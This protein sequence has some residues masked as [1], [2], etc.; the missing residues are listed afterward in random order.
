M[1][2]GSQRTHLRGLAH[3]LRPLVQIGKDGVTQTVVTAVDAVLDAHEL[4][5]VQI[6][7]ER[8]ERKAAA[9]ELEARLGCECAGLIG[10]MAILFRRHR[11]PERQKVVLP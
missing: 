1:L 3:G 2:T 5:K 10:R 8:A 11:D 7:A 9:D 6:Q 4:V